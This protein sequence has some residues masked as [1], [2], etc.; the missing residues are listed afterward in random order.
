MAGL[1]TWTS[2][3]ASNIALFP[4]GM[5]PSAVNDNLRTLQSEVRN[6]YVE[7]EWYDH[8]DT[9]SRASN[10]TFKIAGDVTA[11]Y[12][13]NRRLK[14]FDATTI[15]SIIAS[16]SYSAPDTTITVVNDSGNLS[17]SLTAVALAALKPTSP[18]YGGWQTYTPTVTLV[19]GAGNTV[20]V[21]TTNTGRYCR[22]GNVC[23]V[24]VYLNG[25]GGDEGAGTG[26]FTIAL[27]ITSSS[28]EIVNMLHPCGHALNNATA[29][30][31]MVQPNSNAATASIYYISSLT[32][33]PT[34]FT[35]AEQ[36]NAT[37]QV[38]LHFFYEVI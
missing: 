4:E 29:Y 37:R 1:S 14:C 8:G 7:S 19:G 21:Y 22:I 34:V 25:D 17:A 38:R 35:G 33:A 27:P 6:W 10:T 30:Y 31:L 28:N 12:L 9:P 36:N 5:A 16:S 23:F 26:T 3:S 32:A 11:R 13:A 2:V 15:Y 20:P 18:S 24:D